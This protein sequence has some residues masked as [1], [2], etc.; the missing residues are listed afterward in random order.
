MDNE[1]I[2]QT[3]AFARTAEAY[4]SR[5]WSGVSDEEAREYWLMK[6][7]QNNLRI[8]CINPDRARP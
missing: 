7:A 5:D 4:F 6:S 2:D 1:K 3:V 8:A